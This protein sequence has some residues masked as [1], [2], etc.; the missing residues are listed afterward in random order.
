MKQTCKA[1]DE[2]GIAIVRGHTGM[3]DSLK[4]MVGVCTVYGTVKPKGLIT[5]GGAKAGDLILCTKPLGFETITNYALTNK[6]KAAELFGSESQRELAGMVYMQSCVTEALVLA[7]VEGVDALHDATE[8]GFVSALNELADASKVGLKVIWESIPIPT[9]VLALKARFGLS[10]E[11]VLAMSST[12][13]IL[14]A[15]KPE[16]QVAVKEKLGEL[17]LSGV[18]IGEFMETGERVLVKG[19]KETAFPSTADDPYTLLLAATS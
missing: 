15:V 7:G 2:L 1:A 3:Y 17:G 16:A 12:G 5:S 4:D 11:Q 14:G 8:G 13:T 18:F 9:E 19:K 6:E 10:Y